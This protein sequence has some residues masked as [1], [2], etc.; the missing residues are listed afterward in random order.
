M[1]HKYNYKTYILLACISAFRVLYY[2]ILPTHACGVNADRFER[3]LRNMLLWVPETATIILDNCKIHHCPQI[4]GLLNLLNRKYL[5]LGPYSPEM[6]PIEYFFGYIKLIVKN[7][8]YDTLYKT[9]EEAI[10][11]VTESHLK[12]WIGL[13]KRFWDS[14]EL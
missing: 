2:E 8:N 12:G 6:N 14:N 1:R 7:K 3:F 13:S 4:K 11:E 10:T 5:F 9:V